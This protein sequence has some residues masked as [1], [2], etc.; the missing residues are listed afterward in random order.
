MCL[1]SYLLILFSFFLLGFM[2]VQS[3]HTLLFFVTNYFLCEVDEGRKE[4]DQETG[5]Q[6]ESSPADVSLMLFLCFFL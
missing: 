2:N 4:V 5:N 3:F 1:A 6:N